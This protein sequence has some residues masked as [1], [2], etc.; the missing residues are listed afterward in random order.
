MPCITYFCL[1]VD[2][3]YKYFQS[4]HCLAGLSSNPCKSVTF[5]IFVFSQRAALKCSLFWQKVGKSDTDDRL[6]E[7]AAFVRYFTKTTANICNSL[8]CTSYNALHILNISHRYTAH[9]TIEF[10]HN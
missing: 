10:H 3:T 4:L 8:K 6:L 5:V 2:E 7:A 9:V 1:S